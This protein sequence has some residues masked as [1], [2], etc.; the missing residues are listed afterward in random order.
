MLRVLFNLS[1]ASTL[2]L[3]CIPSAQVSTTKIVGG[4]KVAANDPV[5]ASTVALL[6]DE[7]AFCSGTLIGPQHVVT[8]AHCLYH[9]EPRTLKLGFGPD[10]T[11]SDTA[12]VVDHF[13]HGDSNGGLKNDVGIVVIAGKLPAGVVPAKIAPLSLPQ[14]DLTVI[15]A[16]YGETDRGRGDHG[17]LRRVT[18]KVARF[19]QTEMV[20]EEGLGKGSCTGDSGGPAFV[21]YDGALH[22]IGT[23]SRGTQI[24]CENG[25]GVYMDIRRYQGFMK[26]VFEYLDVPLDILLDDDSRSAC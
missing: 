16:G 14:H 8:A 23:T 1:A 24:S 6:N 9:S 5:A 26:C 10:A 12:F 17:V 25:N 18:T 15:L 20:L 21:D 19:D 11:P 4:E 7:G 3:S 2:L 22:L 13:H